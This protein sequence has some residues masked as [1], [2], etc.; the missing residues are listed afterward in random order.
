MVY[1]DQP[2][3]DKMSVFKPSMPGLEERVQILEK[4]VKIF[5]QQVQELYS[6]IGK[7]VPVEE[8]DAEYCTIS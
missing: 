7:E 1:S 8:E 6:L 4:Q 5:E 2:Y 3:V